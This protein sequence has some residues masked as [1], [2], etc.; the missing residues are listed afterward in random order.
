M[1]RTR[2]KL[3][4]LAVIL[5]ALAICWRLWSF[6]LHPATHQEYKIRAE[7][8]QLR[9]LQP[10]RGSIL[11]RRGGVLAESRSGFDIHF[12]YS[13]LNPRHIV[14]E[15]VC[16]ELARIGDFP[17]VAEMEAG[18]AGNVD[19]EKLESLL[20]QG[21]PFKPEWVPLATWI[22]PAAAERLRLRLGPRRYFRDNFELRVM[23][24][25]PLEAQQAHFD[26]WFRPAEVFRMELTLRRLSQSIDRYDAEGLMERLQLSLKKIEAMVARDIQSDIRSGADALFTRKKERNSRRI[27]YRRGHL[28]APDIS[29]DSVSRIEYNPDLFPGIRIVDSSRRIYPHGEVFGALTG[30][31][32]QLNNRDLKVLEES[33]RLLDRYPKVSSAEAFAVL[34][35]EAL[36]PNDV[37]GGGGLEEQY[38]LSLR[39]EYGMRLQQVG[40][41]GRGGKLLAS[42]SSTRGNDIHTTIDSK[43][44]ELLYRQLWAECAHHGHAAASA[45]LM[46]IPSGAILASTAYPGYDPNRIRDANYHKEMNASLGSQTPDW[47]LD[48]PRSKA[49]YP[50]SIFKIVTAIAALENGADW[51]GAVDP[52]RKYECRVGEQKPFSMRCSSRYGHGHLNLYE[53]FEASCNNY[54]YYLAA[55]HL[56]AGSFNQWARKLG[57]GDLTGIDL[58]TMGGSYDRG[59]L[60]NPEG[61]KGEKALCMYG[62]GQ[63]QVQMTPLQALR[64]VG[65]VA[66]GLKVAPRPWLVKK[67]T[68]DRIYTRNSRTAAIVQECM[69][70]VVSDPHGTVHGKFGLEDFN[71]AAKTGTA[72]YKS[73]NSRYHS[74]MVGYGPLPDPSIAF[75]VVCEK[76]RLGGGDA[77]SPI[78]RELM[79]YLAGGDPRFLANQ[80]SSFNSSRETGAGR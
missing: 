8:A 19:I 11:D 51:E 64:M 20:R 25:K 72:Q 76:S 52:L 26:L 1:A 40:K 41:N 67:K 79:E 70:R 2:L 34:R 46:E 4:M 28:L 58:P 10:L 42:L 17:S 27:F 21:I 45:A 30:H 3:L 39:G 29:L 36:R 31:L 5:P 47:L 63:V 60:E 12:V 61:V 9:T 16:E 48:R 59:F 24:D 50:G 38:D 14:I 7:S 22:P 68:P 32:R 78:V 62:I 65:A 77:C 53:A 49:L 43:L 75:V 44:Q 74:W 54:F 73:N 23:E 71:F 66:T 57:C 18:L 6:Q 33:G 13:D 55:K 15:V 56:D 80:E 69:K 37:V 35:Q